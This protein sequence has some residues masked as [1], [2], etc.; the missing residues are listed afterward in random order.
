MAVTIER[1]GQ[2]V[3][4]AGLPFEAKDRAKREIGAKW[5]GDR[6]QW[7]VGVAKLAAAEELVADLNGGSAARP[8]DG[9]REV[10]E[11]LGLDRETPSGIVADK[12]ADLGRH[13]EA[14]RIR[15]GLTAREDP[16]DIRLTGK[17][18]YKGR[19]YYA[20]R[21]VGDRVVLYTL[22]DEKGEYLEFMAPCAEVEQ[23]KEYRPREVW[24]G[25]R[26]SG[27]TVTQYTTLGSIADFVASQRRLEKQG[28]PQC[29]AC[30]KRSAS[31]VRDLEDGLVKCPGCA[32]IPE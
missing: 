8:T 25:R 2:R 22:P 32:D 16:H 9:S 6:R 26:N 14:K 31:L 29:A 28:V 12:L 20:G 1:A 27:R 21:I 24:D 5:D 18:R 30:G 17:G 13:K 3:Y 23:T 4:L 15:D 19:E 7:W 10:A 11:G